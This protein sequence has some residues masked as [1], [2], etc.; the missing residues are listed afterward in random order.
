M[1]YSGNIVTCYFSHPLVWHQIEVTASKQQ[2]NNQPKQQRVMTVSLRLSATD[3]TVQLLIHWSA[4]CV[5]WS[6]GKQKKRGQFAR[7]R[8]RR[9]ATWVV[10]LKRLSS[11]CYHLLMCVNLSV[12]MSMKEISSS[13]VRLPYFAVGLLVWGFRSAVCWDSLECQGF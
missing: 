6:L 10:E 12:L 3:E 13:L 11:V 9:Q 1:F 5:G 2:T 4:V 8:P 7:E